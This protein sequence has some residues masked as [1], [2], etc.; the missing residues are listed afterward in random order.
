M[1]K[2]PIYGLV[3]TG[4]KSIRMKKDKA[5]LQFH[6]KPQ[7]EHV[8]ELLSGFCE[9]VFV[10]QRK[11]QKISKNFPH[12]HDLKKFSSKGPLSGILSAMAKY[13][14]A[15]WLV[16]ACDLPFVDK[17][18]LKH[19]LRYRNNKKIATAYR[20]RFNDLPEPLC[21]LYEPQ[22][23]KRLLSFFNK[24]I[25]CPRKILINSKPRLLIL[26]NRKA[27]DN[28]NTPEEYRKAKALIPQLT[29]NPR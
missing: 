3:L 12:I 8:Y 29:I 9:K 13:P 11:E 18:T 16:L 6:R 1:V 7:V 5:A 21:A 28:V 22:A 25:T 27:L 24:G 20:S 14:K 4:G 15:A 23:Q 2:A 26:K 17:E 19:L 10:S